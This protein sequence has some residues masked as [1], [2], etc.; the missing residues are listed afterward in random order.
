MLLGN[1]T[2]PRVFTKFQVFTTIADSQSFALDLSGQNQITVAF[3]LRQNTWTDNAIRCLME[4]GRDLAGG[5]CLFPTWSTTNDFLIQRSS[6]FAAF[7]NPSVVTPAYQSY[8]IVIPTASA[9]TAW[10]DGVSQTITRNDGNPGGNFRND[11]MWIASDAGTT[12]F[13]ACSVANFGIWA[14]TETITA[15][16]RTLL[17][18]G[19]PPHQ[20]HPA[21]LLKELYV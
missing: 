10:L 5:V 8:Q 13:N 9:P 14:A 16:E 19:A 12:R 21:G 6:S 4:E 18:A 20:A 7:T 15:G 1:A 2:R 11:T 17:V 3:L